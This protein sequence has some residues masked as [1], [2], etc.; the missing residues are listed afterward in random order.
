MLDALIRNDDIFNN[1]LEYN[2]L[3][4][5]ALT[6]E[7]RSRL[8]TDIGWMYKPHN[9]QKKL[10]QSASKIR[11]LIGGNRAGKTWFGKME[12]RWCA[13]DEHPYMDTKWIKTIWVVGLDRTNMLLGTLIPAIL[14]CIPERYIKS[15]DKRSFTLFLTNG[16][17][18]VF[19]SCDSKV[20][21][22]QSKKVDLI[23]FD[24]EPPYNIYKE[25]YAR[26]IDSAGRI[27]LTM[28]PTNGVSW[29]LDE[30]YAKADSDRITVVKV[31]MRENPYIP[32]KEID[33][34]EAQL[35]PEEKAMRI[36]GDYVV[37][38]GRKIFDTMTLNSWITNKEKMKGPIFVGDI[39]GGNVIQDDRGYFRI[40]EKFDSNSNVLTY[41]GAD[42]SEGVDD[43]TAY[44]MMRPYGNRLKLI[45][46]YNRTI[47]PEKIYN[48]T[49][50]IGKLFSNNLLVM[51][52][53]MN[54]GATLD[55][56]KYEYPG[57][58]YAQ[59]DESKMKS[60]IT[61]KLGWYTNDTRKSKMIRDTRNIMEFLDIPDK[62][63]IIQMQNYIE[64]RRGKIRAQTG[65]DDLVIAV[66][67]AIQGYLSLQGA[68]ATSVTFDPDANR[69]LP[70]INS[71]VAFHMT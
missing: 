49:M 58:I 6:D 13:L 65:K 56:I 3:M 66:M 26:T 2:K 8:S 24:E 59:E 36:A 4:Y 22:F 52:R 38:G 31:N 34:F 20:A 57:Q 68:P 12:V 32:S 30:I 44:A 28:T 61:K 27:I 47:K 42:T 50:D 19:K 60:V 7:I 18:V 54:G 43:N 69:R 25:C 40:Y 5:L 39:Y 45:A 46:C 16:K 14:E 1:S 70:K 17:E 21:K 9:K 35:S 67:L 10:H 29:S 23:W 63:I 11:M 37:L 62:E 33:A 48:V 51:E 41:I 71:R 64:D 15:F 55:R 53:N